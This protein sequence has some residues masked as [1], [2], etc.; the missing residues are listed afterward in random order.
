MLALFYSFF[1]LISKKDHRI[2]IFML[3]NIFQIS[4]MIEKYENEIHWLII[5]P[6]MIVKIIYMKYI[7]KFKFFVLKTYINLL[8]LTTTL[9]TWFKSRYFLFR[10][11]A[12]AIK[13]V[14]EITNITNKCIYKNE[15]A[16]VVVANRVQS[17]GIKETQK[18]MK[19]R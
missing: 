4:R 19:I 15:R 16:Q 14:E 2:F 9:L 7:W 5:M 11:R 10:E 8:S 13:Q 18:K 3:C 12:K 17:R 1:L 6:T